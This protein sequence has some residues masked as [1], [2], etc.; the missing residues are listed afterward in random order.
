MNIST[1]TTLIAFT[2]FFTGGTTKFVLDALDNFF[3]KDKVYRDPND[4]D[5]SEDEAAD[6]KSVDF[7]Y[8]D[9][10]DK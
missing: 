7:E 2:V 4:I 8:S 3:P 1:V 5:E 9:F 6:D 10:I